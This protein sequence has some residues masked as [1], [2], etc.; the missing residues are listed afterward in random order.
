[1]HRR[2]TKSG[3]RSP[4]LIVLESKKKKIQQDL[5]YKLHLIIRKF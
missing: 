4:N 2:R 1:M 3:I 5:K